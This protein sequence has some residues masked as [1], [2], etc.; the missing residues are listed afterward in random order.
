LVEEN[1]PLAGSVVGHRDTTL[2]NII[3]SK[4]IEEGEHH[5]TRG[6]ASEG[7]LMLPIEFKLPSHLGHTHSVYSALLVGCDVSSNPIPH[8][9]VDKDSIVSH[10][11]CELLYQLLVGFKIISK[12]IWVF[13]TESNRSNFDE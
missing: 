12:L 8:A 3:F 1:K 13:L 2:D 10:K 6:V 11:V 7:R 9:L 5:S 4:P